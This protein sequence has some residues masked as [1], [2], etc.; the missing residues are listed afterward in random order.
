MVRIQPGIHGPTL[1]L[2][3]DHDERVRL[4]S[5]AIELSFEG[6]TDAGDE[7]LVI[8]LHENGRAVNT[9]LIAHKTN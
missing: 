2:P 8:T 9:F 5:I 1:L 7:L 4:D 6:A 3:D